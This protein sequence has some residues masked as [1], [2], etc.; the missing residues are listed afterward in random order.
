MREFEAQLIHDMRNT[1]CVIR[2]AA[3]TLH[4]THESMPTAALSDI[5][6]MLTR[7]SDMLVRLLEDLATMHALDRGD[8]TVGLQSVDLTETCDDLISAYQDQL[9]NRIHVELAA[10]ALVLG[11][12]LRI[13]QVLDNLLSNAA[14]HGG[15]EVAV[16]AWLEGHEVRVAVT[17]DGPGVPEALVD[18]L[19][20]PYSRGGAS[21]QLGGSGLGLAIVHRL[22]AAMGGSIAYDNT[23]GTTFT[24]TL[25]AVPHPSGRTRKDA[26]LAGHSVSFWVEDQTLA[27]A[28]T[29]YVATGLANG[30]GV[31]IAMTESHRALVATCLAAR[32]FDLDAARTIGQY[33]ELDADEVSKA[34]VLDGR[35]SPD[36]F[37]AIIGT[38]IRT[39]DSRWRTFRVFGEIVDVYWRAGSGDLSLQLENCWNRLRATVDFPLYCG[40]QVSEEQESLRHCHDAV[41]VA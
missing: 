8:L 37:E 20:D 33:L 23:A 38:T 13:T 28:V 30:E 15:H 19:F 17:D 25:P 21:Q 7:R 29:D 3:E 32:G 35:V 22:C 27:D 10:D 6:G 2:G 1:A 14:R 9:G 39:I 26:A 34:I 16:R 41:L 11:D 31:A 40:Y 36:R 5:T 4:L 12:P 24:V 18:S